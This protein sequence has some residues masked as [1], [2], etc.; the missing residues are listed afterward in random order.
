MGHNFLNTAWILTKILLDIDIDGFS[1]NIVWFFHDGLILVVF[2]MFFWSPLFLNYMN[3][4][5]FGDSRTIGNSVMMSSS[6]FAY[7]E[8]EQEGKTPFHFE[9]SFFNFSAITASFQT[10]FWQLV[11]NNYMFHMPGRQPPTPATSRELNCP[12]FN[13]SNS[14]M[15]KNMIN[16]QIF[17]NGT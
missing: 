17:E 12:P 10:S 6:S 9:F 5:I 7:C 2:F 13:M 8:F 15:F 11:D 16:I 4:L 3:Y 14:T 1:S